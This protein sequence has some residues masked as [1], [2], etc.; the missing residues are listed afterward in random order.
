L[1]L[2]GKGLWPLAQHDD[3]AGHDHAGHD[4]AGHD[5]GTP[6][7]SGASELP[8]YERAENEVAEEANNQGHHGHVPHF[9]DINWFYGLLG[10]KKDAEPSLLWRPPGMPAPLGALLINTAILFYVLGRFGGPGIRQGLIDRKERIAGDIDKAAKMKAEAEEQLAYHEEKLE[11]MEAEMTRIKKEMAEQAEADRARII[12]EAKE[13]RAAIEAES[14]K[15]IEQELA[16]ARHDATLRAVSAA[17]AAARA[18]V[19]KNMNTQDQERLAQ[20]FL[21]NLETEAKKSTG[22]VS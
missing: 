18:Q 21:G 22:A 20:D 13:R 14:R 16:Q 2:V 9:S 12:A 6:D 10:E 15:L 5:H 11:R 3:H 8:G 19:V 17:V 1:A 7:H 4:H